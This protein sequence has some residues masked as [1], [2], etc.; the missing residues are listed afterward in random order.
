MDTKALNLVPMVVEQTARGERA[1]DIYTRLLKE[2]VIFMVGPVDDHVCN[3][4]V[5][6]LLFLE[7]EDP[8]RD[9]HLYINS[10]GGSPVQS[11]LIGA[12][13][14]RLAKEKEV[15][16]IEAHPKRQKD[17]PLDPVVAG[18]RGA[19]L[20]FKRPGAG[21]KYYKCCHGAYN[22]GVDQRTKHGHQSLAHRL[23]GAGCC[24]GDGG[25][26]KTGFIGKHPARNPHADA[27]HH[28][29]S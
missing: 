4:V 10:P 11:S 28:A 23:T 2:R 27:H 16:V 15:P 20:S 5:A 12:R 7:A 14:R 26:A 3:L 18:Q 24:M 17:S 29:G 13:I 8:E 25:T 6:Q 9:I 1:Y 22:E 19:A 21:C